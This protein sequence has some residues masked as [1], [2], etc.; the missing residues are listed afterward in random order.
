MRSLNVFNWTGLVTIMTT[1]CRGKDG[2][3]MVSLFSSVQKRFGEGS[4]QRDVLSL[5]ETSGFDVRWG[6]RREQPG[7]SRQSTTRRT[8]KVLYI[9]RII[10]SSS[11]R[12]FLTKNVWL[13]PRSRTRKHSKNNQPP[14]TNSETLIQYFARSSHRQRP[15]IVCAVKKFTRAVVGCDDNR[16]WRSPPP[17]SQGPLYTTTL[18]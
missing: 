6:Q 15:E 11:V 3:E 1:L 2:R 7:G 13:I 10:G 12:F 9:S 14:P 16:L 8:G 5:Q 4:V 17:S 18:L